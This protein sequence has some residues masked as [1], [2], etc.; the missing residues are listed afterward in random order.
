MVEPTFRIRPGQ[1]ASFRS[2]H[3][4]SVVRYVETVLRRGDDWQ[5]VTWVAV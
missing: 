4:L 1:V 2:K 5:W 3:L